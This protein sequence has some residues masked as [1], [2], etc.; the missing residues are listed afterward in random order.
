MCAG[1][2]SEDSGEGMTL[3]DQISKA[4]S[5]ANTAEAKAKQAEMKINHLQKS[6]KVSTHWAHLSLLFDN[7]CEHLD[8]NDN[9][10]LLHS[11]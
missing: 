9:H 7:R 10:L 11:L 5:D 8:N 1:I 3:P 6:T 4:H 2:S